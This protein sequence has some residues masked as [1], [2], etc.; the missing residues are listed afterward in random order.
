MLRIPVK[1]LTINPGMAILQKL[2]KCL[3]KIL[4]GNMD[5]GAFILIPCCI[6]LPFFCLL[7]SLWRIQDFTNNL[8]LAWS[9]L[10]KLVVTGNYILV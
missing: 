5:L 7:S 10:K 6:F 8:G 1:F 9:T 4:A 2:L 3:S